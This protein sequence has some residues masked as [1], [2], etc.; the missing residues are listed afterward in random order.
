MPVFENF[1]EIIR[2]VVHFGAPNKK[3]TAIHVQYPPRKSQSLAY[4]SNALKALVS[5]DCGRAGSAFVSS[6]LW[7]ERLRVFIN[8][9]EILNATPNGDAMRQCR[10][11]DERCDCALC[12]LETSAD[13]DAAAG[14]GRP[15]SAP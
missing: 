2:I 13:R 3:L 8:S 5:R 11:G 14:D 1:T 12:F 6:T 4:S 9:V 10:R 7:R 15:A